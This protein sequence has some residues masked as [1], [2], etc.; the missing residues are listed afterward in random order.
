MS[1]PPSPPARPLQSPVKATHSHIVA[2]RRDGVVEGHQLRINGGGPGKSRFFAAGKHGGADKALA[3]AQ[4]V[5][6]ELGLPATLTNAGGNRM[7]VPSQAN[8]TGTAGIRFTW[9]AA[10]SAPILRVEASWMDKRGRNRHTSYSVEHNGLAGA[11]DKAI[12]ARVSA[13]APLPDR[14]MLLERL[15]AVYRNGAPPGLGADD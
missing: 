8:I 11:L 15:V 1:Q 5:A 14:D 10:A 9:V 2:I 12:T 3:E 6:R 13:G 7:G 4:R